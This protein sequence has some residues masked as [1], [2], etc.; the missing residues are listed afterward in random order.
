VRWDAIVVGGGPAGAAC[1]HGMARAGLAVLLLDRAAA[2]RDKPCG[3]GLLPRGVAALARAGLAALVDGAAPFEGVR[4]HAPSGA[5]ATGRFRHGSGL[6]VRRSRFDAA[7]VEAAAAAGACVRFGSVVRAIGPFLDGG[8]DVLLDGGRERARVV[9]LAD[10]GRSPLAGALG[11]GRPRPTG[12]VGVVAHGAGAGPLVEAHF[13]DGWQVVLTPLAGGAFSVAALVEPRR[14]RELGGDPLGWLRARLDERGLAVAGLDRARCLPLLGPA[15][16]L[17]DDGLLLVGDAGGA[18]DPIVGC[19]IA[20]ALEGAADAGHAIAA[21][22]D[23]SGADRAAL[24]PYARARRRRDR[25]PR[26][27]CAIA[28]A[29]ARSPRVA[30]GA[31][32]VLGR[33]TWA[34][35]GLLRAVAEEPGDG[36]PIGG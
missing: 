24:A 3:E 15:P 26:A 11:L 7:L 6:G 23:G 35:D 16:R 33:C 1:A 34:L 8:R 27:A 4:F 5:A 18:V 25:A 32:R 31:A 17:V 12:R 21:A 36:V 10:G 20:L 29:A 22:L 9:V 19:G 2:G 28:L 14:A 13:A 30:E